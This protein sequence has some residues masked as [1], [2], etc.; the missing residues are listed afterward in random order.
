MK[1]T[2]D[3]RTARATY[4]RRTVRRAQTARRPLDAATH[5]LDHPQTNPAQSC[6]GA[7]CHA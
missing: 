1:L 6:A 3:L 4:E 2:D 7:D 5:H